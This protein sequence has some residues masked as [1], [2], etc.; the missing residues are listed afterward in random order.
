MTV[1]LEAIQDAQQQPV[2]VHRHPE[3]HVGHACITELLGSAQAL[4]DGEVE[5]MGIVT[6]EVQVE[7]IPPGQV[8]QIQWIVAQRVVPG[9]VLFKYMP[10]STEV[11]CHLVHHVMQDILHEDLRIGRQLQLAVVQGCEHARTGK[12][13]GHL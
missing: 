6:T 12:A 8:E 3:G 4:G 5:R 13:H 1:A 2:R 11:R 7:H 9:G 10:T